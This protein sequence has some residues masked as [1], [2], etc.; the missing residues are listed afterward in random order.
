VT[1]VILT[2]FGVHLYSFCY[3]IGGL[4]R[5]SGS[6]VP[7]NGVME[8]P[9]QEI[10]Q[11]VC[12]EIGNL[13]PCDRISLA[14]PSHDDARFIVVTLHPQS[15]GAPTWEVPKEG[16]CAAQ[17][18]KRKKA[19]FCPS[20]GTE[21]RYPEEERLHRQGMRDAAF[22]PLL[23]GGEPY[24]VLILASREPSSLEGKS[25]R[26]LERVG[27]LVATAI[28]ATRWERPASVS[29]V[30][31]DSAGG[32]STA[33]QRAYR[34]MVA[35][36]RVSNR[37]VQED[38]LEAACRL[39]LDTM[40]EHSGYRRAVLTLL[41]TEGKDSQWFFTGFND[42]DIDYFHAHK[43]KPAQR[44][45]LFQERYKTG[46]SYLVPASAGI[47]C[48]GLRAAGEGTAA[49]GRGGTGDLLLIPLYGAKGT[50]VGTVMLA[51]AKEPGASTAEALSSLEL[52]ASEVA[53]AIE[54]KRLDQVVKTAQA[55]LRAAQEQLMQ[56]EKMSAI[57]QLIS[58][59][60]HELNNPLSGVMGFAQLLLGTEVNPKVKK[61][62]ERIYNEAV[63]CQR[64]VQNLLTFSRRHKPEKTSRSLNE[65]VESVLELR[66]YQLQVDDVE[67]ERR[68]DAGLPST[69]LD[70]H[71]M[72]QVI[73]NVVN[74]AHHAMMQAGGR[75]RRLV[76]VTEHSGNVVR[77][78][79]TDTGTGI[80]RERLGQIFD[81][82]FTTKESGKGTGLGLSVS[83]AIVKD[84]QGTIGA[85]SLL[86][87]GTTITIELPI[88]GGEEAAPVRDEAKGSQAPQAP[89][90][91]LVV[92][93]EE[94]LVE[95]L[96][97]FLKSA[98]HTVDTARDGRK[99]LE[100]AKTRD[101]DIILSDLK[102]P[103]LDG[104]GLY[105]QLLKV[106]PDM[107]P[108]FIFSTGDL[109]NPKVQT[110]FQS[111]GSLYLSKPF[112]LESVLKVL[113]QLARRLRAA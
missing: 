40:R 13:V 9:A 26:L 34:Q 1:F 113:D 4:G 64:I 97:D 105:E 75:A 92:D 32:P 20:L 86:G 5:S 62:L 14:L 19:E 65:V 73:L 42:D 91:L 61:N 60:T 112:K 48:G 39:F 82:F 27:S 94:V 63:R 11:Q 50:V 21:F 67:V 35:F 98:G 66:A 56:A 15:E 58:G 7:T 30:E 102:M 57:G 85:E 74:N 100:L 17:V 108:R 31:T 41:D 3:K 6:H 109:A 8:H 81:P 16:S 101:Y 68:F 10:F 38:D 111:T 24:G 55:R 43:L 72:Q 78:R 99:A 22:L 103:G 80:P 12:R 71:Q 33:L 51:D 37:I 47:D 76:A 84:H 2:V 45:A 110:F 49:A 44:S 79:F 28:A 104:Q 46:N 53:H 59:V 107:A 106:K 36:S 54:K 96:S 18:L 90:R 77:A 88:V 69:M 87:E 95:L 52:F 89:L 23:L 70:F 93:D 25:V 83:R 29:A